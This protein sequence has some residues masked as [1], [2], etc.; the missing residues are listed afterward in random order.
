[1]LEALGVDIAV[2]LAILV[3]LFDLVPLIGLTI[4]GLVVAV[5]AAL[6]A[7][8]GALIVWVVAFLGFQQLQDRV[9]QP[10]LYGRAVKV[11]PLIA[12][13]V[14]FAGAQIAGILGALLAIPVAASIAVVFKVLGGGR[15]PAAIAAEPAEP[16]TQPA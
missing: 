16:R 8:P 7:F 2:P 3:A 14:L 15:G 13:L 10:L 4:G 11:N 9:V 1:M 6:H 5:V 12:I